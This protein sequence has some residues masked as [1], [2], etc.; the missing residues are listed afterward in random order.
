MT[1][2]A[3]NLDTLV[4]RYVDLSD[5][6]DHLIAARNEIIDQLRDLGPGKHPTGSGLVVTVSPPSRRFNAARA[7]QMLSPQQLEL[8]HHDGYDAK[9]IKQFLPPVLLD[10]CMDPGT[11]SAMVKVG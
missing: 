3:T 2:P 8:C 9:K 10:Q 1:D 4:A 6:I 5:H 11:G 7:E